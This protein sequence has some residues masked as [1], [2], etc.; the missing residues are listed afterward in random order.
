MC[1]ASADCTPS[2]SSPLQSS[3]DAI[4]RVIRDICQPRFIERRHRRRQQG[5]ARPCRPAR[6]DGSPPS[7]VS[8]SSPVPVA[9]LVAA[10]SLRLAPPCVHAPLPSPASSLPL[11]APV[12][13]CLG[14]TPL[15]W[16]GLAWSGRHRAHGGPPASSSLAHIAAPRPRRRTAL[17]SPR[18]GR[19][20]A[21]LSCSLGWHYG[22]DYMDMLRGYLK[23]SIKS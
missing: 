17:R 10:N 16:S 11:A 15:C 4:R 2:F 7:H 8:R 20:L 18:L 22:H 12:L 3:V 6:L 9:R 19:A 1:V 13:S 5:H 21:A 14:A 23:G